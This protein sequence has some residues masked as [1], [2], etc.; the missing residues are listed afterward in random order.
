MILRATE[1]AVAGYK[2][3]AGR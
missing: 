1:N 2:W 3:S